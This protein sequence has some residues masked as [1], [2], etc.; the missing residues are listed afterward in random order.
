MFF[1]CATTV[2]IWFVACASTK[3]ANKHKQEN[4]RGFSVVKGTS[5]K[6]YMLLYNVFLNPL[7]M[8]DKAIATPLNEII[9]EE[10][11]EYLWSNGV[12]ERVKQIANF[13]FPYIHKEFRCGTF[14]D[15]IAATEMLVESANSYIDWLKHV[16]EVN[17][18]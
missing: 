17:S 2:Y 11:V 3:I 8:S 10:R 16:K 15:L 7:S 9:P 14:D 13:N 1:K 12:D 4:P 6:L 5:N 18:I